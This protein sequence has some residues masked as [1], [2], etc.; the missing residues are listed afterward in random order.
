MRM[1]LSVMRPFTRRSMTTPLTET[2]RPVAGTPRKSPR[3]VPVQVKRVTTLSPEE[4][5]SSVTQ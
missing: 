3:W 2:G 4:M 5:D 1:R